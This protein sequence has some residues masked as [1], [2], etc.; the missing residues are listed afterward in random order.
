MTRTLTAR[1]LSPLAASHRLPLIAL[2]AVTVAAVITQW[3]LRR[4]SRKHLKQ[5]DDHMLEDIGV[6]RSEAMKEAQRPFW[7]P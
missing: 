2:F 6:T 4:R 5:L 7:L 3:D 1:T